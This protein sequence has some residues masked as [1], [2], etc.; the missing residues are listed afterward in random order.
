MFCWVFSRCGRLIGR[1]QLQDDEELEWLITATQGNAV[2]MSERR[3]ET[4]E[5]EY[6]RLLF[7]ES[8]IQ[9]RYHTRGNGLDFSK[10]GNSVAMLR[11]NKKFFTNTC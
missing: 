3:R 1:F 11:M 9:V 6:H 4:A 5:T 7:Q 2:E 10:P 8:M